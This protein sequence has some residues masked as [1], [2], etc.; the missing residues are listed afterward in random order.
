MVPKT[1]KKG[2]TMHTDYLKEFN[3][4]REDKR[5]ADSHLDVLKGLIK[6]VMETFPKGIPAG[7]H[8]SWSSFLQY[9][10]ENSSDALSAVIEHPEIW[11]IICDQNDVMLSASQS[12]FNGLRYNPD[13]LIGSYKGKLWIERPREHNEQQLN[14]AA[15]LIYQVKQKHFHGTHEDAYITSD[16]EVISILQ[17]RLSLINQSHEIIGYL[18]LVLTIQQQKDSE[19]ALKEIMGHIMQGL[20]QKNVLELTPEIQQYLVSDLMRTQVNI[21]NVMSNSIDAILVTSPAG[22]IMSSNQSFK[23][24]V[25]YTEKELCNQPVTIV[26][27]DIGTHPLT[28]GGAVD[29]DEQYFLT[30]AK[31]IDNLFVSGKV[32]GFKQYFNNKDG[33]LIPTEVNI[34]L[35]RDSTG[36]ITGF[37]RNI[38]D[39]SEKARLQRELMEKEEK[40]N[41]LTRELTEQY[42]P[43]TIVGKSP[44]M[45]NIFRLITKV[46][47]NDCNVLIQGESGTGKEL[48]AHAL[49]QHSSR[50]TGPFVVLNCGAIPHDLLESE[51]FGHKKGA[52]TG[53]SRD[54]KGLF[55]EAQGGVIFLDEI[56]ELPLDMQVKLLRAIQEHEIRRVGDNL[57]VKIDVRII[58]ATHRDLLDE[59]RN[60][61]FREDLYYRINVVTIK[62]PP[63]RERVEDIPP[64][65]HFFLNK[66]KGGAHNISLS[67]EAMKILLSYPYPGNVRELEHIIERARILCEGTTIKLSDLPSEVIAPL[68]RRYKKEAGMQAEGLRQ[69][70]TRTRESTERD[71]ILKA[72]KQAGDNKARTAQYLQIGRTSLYRKLKKLGLS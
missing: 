24:L 19:N 35:L 66:H 18:Y 59:T 54:K 55:E 31:M 9:C 56:G 14:R 41:H 17:H 42:M 63:L 65:I 28:I 4:L 3:R 43:N 69:T 61:R 34:S 57:S 64:L 60:K 11:S 52:F 27:P 37:V 21:N 39:L 23:K 26:S 7:K 30:M 51:L 12:L 6:R 62:I 1:S 44:S 68:P 2:D 58:A 45:Q 32:Y 13:E 5:Q 47:D 71:M 70:I 10:R 20:S 15:Y 36:E 49:Y 40:I 29:I 8:D 48:I 50:S 25:G 72:L 53:A 67:R 33:F 22:L 16:G 38:R 46:A